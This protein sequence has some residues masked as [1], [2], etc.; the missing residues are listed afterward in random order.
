MSIDRYRLGVDFGTSSTVAMLSGPGARAEL[1]LFD[2][3]PLLPSAVCADATGTLLVGRDA[4]HAGLSTPE[5]FEPHPKRRIDEGVVLL[6]AEVPVVDLIAAVLA[7]VGTEAGQIIGGRPDSTVVTCP[8]SWAWPRRRILSEAATVAGLPDVRL[9]AEPIAAAAYLLTVAGRRVP[10]NVPILVYDLGAGTFDASVVVR[11]STGFEVLATRGLDD[12]GGLDIDAAVVAAIGPAADPV[13][14]RL[15]APAT[16][17]DRRAARQ[18]WDGA[19]LAKESLGR[20]PS[21]LIH[22]PLLDVEAPL[23]REQLD[24]LARPIIGR[25]IGATQAVLDAHGLRA[26]DLGT[27]LLVGAGSRLPLVTTM[28]RQAFGVDPMMIEQPE[29]VV[30]KGSVLAADPATTDKPR[31]EARPDAGPLP[32]EAAVGPQ[33]QVVTVST[34]TPAD[35]VGPPRPRDPQPSWVTDSN[36]RSSAATIVVV[37]VVLILV[38]AIGVRLSRNSDSSGAGAKPTTAGSSPSASPSPSPSPAKTR[39]PEFDVPVTLIGSLDMTYEG[40]MRNG[41]CTPI[42]GADGQL[43]ELVG[44]EPDIQTVPAGIS[45]VRVVGFLNPTGTGCNGRKLLWVTELKE[46]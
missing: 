18:L 2:G 45:R 19:R 40:S 22:I 12:T 27:V 39:P 36:R 37:V 16:V 26:A 7:R 5:R 14:Q 4:L 32:Q 34:P 38:I 28:L 42:D 43:Y 21:T 3:S 8:A 10:D 35:T 23:G 20:L 13:W 46:V 17:A 29:L 33:R 6:G 11:R 1:V 44:A 30:A 9:V 31:R 24:E 25:T 41:W 15:R